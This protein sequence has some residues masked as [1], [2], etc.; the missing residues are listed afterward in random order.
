[1]TVD[2]LK[3][4]LDAGFKRISAQLNDL[5][6]KAEVRNMTIDAR[7]EL[8]DETDRIEDWDSV[9]ITGAEY[10]HLLDIQHKYYELRE[11]QHEHCRKRNQ[12]KFAND[13]EWQ[14]AMDELEIEPEPENYFSRT[15]GYSDDCEPSEYEPS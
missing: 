6:N 1:M 9:I 2:D 4:T 5:I 14:K 11:A 10:L 13:P 12:Q 15:C 7:N 3:R 8:M